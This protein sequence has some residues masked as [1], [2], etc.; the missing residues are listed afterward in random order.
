M[1]ENLCFFFRIFVTS[2]IL[3]IITGCATTRYS[4]KTIST[5]KSDTL[6]IITDTEDPQVISAEEFNDSISNLTELINTARKL[7]D[8]K[9]FNEADSILKIVIETAGLL[10][11]DSISYE[12]FLNEIVEIYTE[13]MPEEFQIP[14]EIITLVN[15]QKM[16][17]ALDSISFAS[18]SSFMQSMLC[19]K[20]TFYNMPVVWNERV[21]RATYYY[22]KNRKTTIDHWIPRASQYLAIM[23]KIIAEYGLPEDLAYLPLIES[24]FRPKAYSRAHASGIWQFIPSTG[25][26]YGLRNN[27]WL[28]ERR[29][30]LKSTVAAA[31]YLKKLYE[32]FNDWHLALAAYNCGEGGLNRA[33]NRSNSRNYWDLNLPRETMNYVPL[34][35][36]ALTI[37]KN[38]S[39]FNLDRPTDTAT[40]LFDTVRISECLD[41]RDIAEGTGIDYD[42]L[43]KINPHILHW[44][45]PPDMSDVLLYLP[46]GYSQAFKDFHATIPD[47]KKVKWYR[48]K[49]QK[50]DNIG[51]IARRFKVPAEPIRS[52]N[53][54]KNNNI[55]AGKY[56]FIPIPV[57]SPTA[58]DGINEQ[59]AKK[60]TPSED[61][62]IKNGQEIIYQ[63]KAGDSVWKISE[64]F[65][66]SPDQICAWNKLN[67]D[68]G[69]RVGQ[70]LTLY[71]N[72]INSS[73][74]KSNK[75]S[76]SE[77]HMEYRVQPGDTPSSIARKFA[78][79]VDELILLNNLDSKKPVIYADGILV[80]KKRQDSVSQSMPSPQKPS[81]NYK[82]MKYQV[83]AGETL[84][85]ISRIFS[86]SVQDLR[87]LN[88]LS[89]TSVIRAGDTLLIPS[90][91]SIKSSALESSVVFYE[92][93][94]GDNLWRIANTFGISV[95]NL[96][97]H[98]NLRPDSVLMPGDIIKVVRAG[99]M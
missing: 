3:L 95:Q 22:Y 94:E 43:R 41:L 28:D 55:I 54:L 14:E 15:D 81:T 31:R 89:E 60:Q 46:N 21:L 92:V 36:A 48:Y 26:T 76:L 80:V 39:C 72:P 7:C 37:A 88:N 67:D 69:I 1:R 56:L 98:N 53:R 90:N 34:F 32:E 83:S 79:S 93:E 9:N 63:V 70:L 24:G 20:S 59:L 27:Y 50:G 17:K 19:G 62:L 16:F 52:I 97:K 18:D 68:A 6:S 99:E 47:S 13:I 91:T 86:V 77:E 4:K 40:F 2:G 74:K 12:I 96:Y 87:S 85:G 61:P 25:K 73:E 23:K 11:S 57:G 75:P 84:F 42:T 30:P 44:C 33:I 35:L 8:E 82:R 49:I 71:Q 38:P 5:E 78:M 45:T 29:D 10:S 64:L 58:G 51:S 65:G 66:I